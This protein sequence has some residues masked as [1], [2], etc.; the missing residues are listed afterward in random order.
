MPESTTDGAYLLEH[1]GFQLS[2]T[3]SALLVDSNGIRKIHSENLTPRHCMPT[4]VIYP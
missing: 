2:A 3:D 1:C 4:S